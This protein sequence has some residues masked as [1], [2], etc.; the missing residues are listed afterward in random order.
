MPV[1]AFFM[2][3]GNI[4][5]VQAGVVDTSAQKSSDVTKPTLNAAVSDG[6]LTVSAVD[7][8]SGVKAIYINGYEF[9][10]LTDGT[11]NVRLQQFDAGYEYFTITA[12]DNAGNVSA[13]YKVANP[14]YTDAESDDGTSDAAEQLPVSAVATN[15]TQATAKVTEHT[16]TKNADSED[17]EDEDTT[18]REFYTI[19]TSSEKVFYLIIDRDGDDE[20]VYFLTEISENDLLNTTSDNSETLP[21]NSAALESSIPVSESALSNNNTGAVSDDTEL[22]ESTED[23]EAAAEEA[24]ALLKQEKQQKLGSLVIYGIVGVIAVAVIIVYYLMK[25]KK[26]NEDFVDD[27]ENDDPDDDYEE[28]YDTDDDDADDNADE[29]F[30]N[31]SDSAD[32]EAE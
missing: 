18:G 29:A 20:T 2:S 23:T 28:E 13:A 9:T 16:V 14:Y 32:D 27:D 30:I 24:A 25:K 5:T 11:L 26:K 22:V 4:V 3:A 8:E 21:K 12:V 10:D 19:Q 1:E 15:K 7:T 31:N 17:D 6:M